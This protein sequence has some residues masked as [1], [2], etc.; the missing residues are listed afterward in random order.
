MGNNSFELNWIA[1]M[2]YLFWLFMVY[3]FF[4]VNL[5]WFGGS[6]TMGF[7]N[8]TTIKCIELIFFI[9]FICNLKTRNKLI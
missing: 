5:F 1:F 9:E 8:R 7:D 4:M 3:C 2:V 6:A